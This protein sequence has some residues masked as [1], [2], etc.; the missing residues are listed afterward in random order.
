MLQKKCVRITEECDKNI[1]ERSDP[2]H[3]CRPTIWHRRGSPGFAFV[4]KIVVVVVIVV[5]AVRLGLRRLPPPF[6]R[7]FPPR[8]T[9]LPWALGRCLDRCLGVPVPS[10]GAVGGALLRDRGVWIRIR[11]HAGFPQK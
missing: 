1:K 8:G 2:T 3:H 9:S 11:L 5:I 10:L 7:Q 4:F 6:R